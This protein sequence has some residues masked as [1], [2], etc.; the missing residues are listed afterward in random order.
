MQG[1]ISPS[2]CDLTSLA[3]F[4][5]DG[6]HTASSCQVKFF[7]APTSL[8]STGNGINYSFPDDI[9]IGVTLTD[10][11]LSHNQLSG[12]IPQQ[13]Q[14]HPWRNS[15][16]LSYN[17]LGGTLRED[18][19]RSRSEGERLSD[20]HD[21]EQWSS[22][23]KRPEVSP[24]IGVMGSLTSWFTVFNRSTE[25]NVVSLQ[26][27]TQLGSFLSQYRLLCSAIT[28][29]AV[30][31]NCQEQSRT[32]DKES[33]VSPI[34]SSSLD[35][36]A[37]LR[38]VG[39][40]T[41]KDSP[42]NVAVLIM[43]FNNLAAPFLATAL[44][45]S[46]CFYDVITT[47]D[48]VFVTYLY[49]SCGTYSYDKKTGYTWL[50]MYL[51]AHTPRSS[52]IH[53]RVTAMLPNI[54]KPFEAQTFSAA[55]NTWEKT[56]MFSLMDIAFSS[57]LFDCDVF[58][59]QLVNFLAML[60]TF[61]VVFPPVAVVA[62]VVAILSITCSAQLYIGRFV[63]IATQ[64]SS[65]KVDASHRSSALKSLAHDCS[66]ARAMFLKS[67][68]IAAP[69]ALLFYSF[70]LFDILGDEVGWKQAV[71]LPVA[72]VMFSVILWLTVRLHFKSVYTRLN[73]GEDENCSNQDLKEGLLTVI[74]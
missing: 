62:L 24:S 28:L 46:N 54:L 18:F 64:N 65:S 47:P 5:L 26:N 74:A 9:Q 36:I 48:S 27:V 42:V 39:A 40:N 67:L 60:A 50:L 66:G 57:R 68:W 30:L 43:L 20:A 12:T 15:L 17:K 10:L 44:V 11:S 1:S 33:R 2:V 70:L 52:W 41:S 4:D 32:S 3:F 73:G 49:A 51:H 59:V 53:K 38:H 31:V 19:P 22:L 21:G 45:S 16:D 69:F 71:W 25:E 7:P 37:E 58:V 34:H 72:I 29:F 55:D 8:F 6:L 56:A 63:C 23:T 14:S 61:G 13:I 35:Q